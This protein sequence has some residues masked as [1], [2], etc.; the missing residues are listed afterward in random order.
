M[1]YFY[2]NFVASMWV[3]IFYVMQ[4]L[5]NYIRDIA[6]V[7]GFKADSL[8]NDLGLWVGCPPCGFSKRS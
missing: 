8:T 3:N 2:P 4:L 5:F 7:V 1:A 6:V